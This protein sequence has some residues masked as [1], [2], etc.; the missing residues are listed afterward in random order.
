[1]RVPESRPS[2]SGTDQS[3][4]SGWADGVLPLPAALTYETG[5][6][7][8][9]GIPGFWDITIPV[10]HRTREGAIHSTTP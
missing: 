8:E 5:L 9:T 4:Q 10:G 2:G 3:C 1:M 6:S 7:L